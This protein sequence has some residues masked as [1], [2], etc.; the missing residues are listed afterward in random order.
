MIAADMQQFIRE[1]IVS[2]V[3]FRELGESRLGVA[4][5]MTFA[6]GDACEMIV[7]Q[8]RD[9]KWL[10]SDEGYVLALAK[11]QGINLLSSG[12]SD[13]FQ[14]LTKYFGANADDGEVRLVAESDSLGDA[15][16]AFCQTCM[17]AAHLMEQPPDAVKKSKAFDKRF[18]RIV[19][20]AIPKKHLFRKWFDEDN[21]PEAIYRADYRTGDWLIFGA[22]S[23][24]KAWKGV[25]AAQHIK[26]KRKMQ[27]LFVFSDNAEKDVA[28]FRAIVDNADQ[29]FSVT[30]ERMEVGKFLRKNI[31]VA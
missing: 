24:T 8:Q 16:F 19:T 30:R 11:M 26:A 31:S 17:E 20:A 28:A 6:D 4:F 22:G 18:N 27:T 5:P 1:Q 10:I 13:R 14:E 9:G 12:Y 23:P 25:A 2:E 7:Q 3:R 21:D 29:I 15:L